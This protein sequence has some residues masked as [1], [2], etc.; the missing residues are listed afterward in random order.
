MGTGT[1]RNVTGKRGT[2]FHATLVPGCDLVKGA[3]LGVAKSDLSVTEKKVKLL[4]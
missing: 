4:F 3:I 1:L 2:H